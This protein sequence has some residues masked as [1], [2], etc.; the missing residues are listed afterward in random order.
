MLVFGI[1]G[2]YWWLLLG[3]DWLII[4]SLTSNGEE[5]MHIR[6]ENK[7]NII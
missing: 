2:W 6:D 7:F 3:V 1:D 4:G 5:F